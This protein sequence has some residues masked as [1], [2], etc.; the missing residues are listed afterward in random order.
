LSIRIEKLGVHR[1]IATLL[2]I[3]LFLLAIA[4]LVVLLT[5]Q[6]TDLVRDISEIQKHVTD[7]IDKVRQYIAET[8]KISQEKQEELIHEQQSPAGSSFT[9]GMVTGILGIFVDFILVLVYTFLF[10]FSRSHLRTALL[11]IV[12]QGERRNTEVIVHDA[13]KVAQQYLTGLASMIVILWI[14]YAIGFSIIGVKN[15]VFFAVLCGLLEIVPFVG[16][17]TGTSVTMLMVISQGG[18]T[19]MVI[20]VFL[21][22]LFIQFFQSY[23]LEPLVVGA[24]VNINPIF[25]I[26]ILVAGEML[27]G[28]PGMVLAI[29]ILGIIKIICDH[30]EPL[31]PYGFL[32]GQGSNKNKDHGWIKKLKKFSNRTKPA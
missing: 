15:A 19:E 17:I 3:V 27:W 14:M 2:C 26:L 4:G 13:S 31:K 32:I 24:E 18:S 6:I 23:V 11:K 7:F 21:T 5:W 1:A 28:I 25:T 8:F 12:P 22:Y 10:M 16:N 30:I 20:G 29:P 9:G